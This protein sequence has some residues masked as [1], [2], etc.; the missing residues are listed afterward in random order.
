[1]LFRPNIDAHVALI[2]FISELLLCQFISS[3]VVSV[4]I[5]YK[6]LNNFTAR[7]ERL[8]KRGRYYEKSMQRSSIL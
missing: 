8:L 2:V 3:F 5:L 1:M 7:C 4:D 6:T